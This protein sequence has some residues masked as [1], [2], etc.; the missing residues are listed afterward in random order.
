MQ[1]GRGNQLHFS[2]IFAK[3]EENMKGRFNF[4]LAALCAILSVMLIA[5]ALVQAK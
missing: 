4:K 3:G 2:Q 5:P 1:P